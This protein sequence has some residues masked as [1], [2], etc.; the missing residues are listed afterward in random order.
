MCGLF[1]KKMY[2]HL[3]DGTILVPVVI[4]G[5]VVVGVLALIITVCVIKHK[6]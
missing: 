1:N 4:T 3:T 2:L 6:P 5:L